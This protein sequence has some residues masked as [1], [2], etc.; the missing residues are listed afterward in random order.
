MVSE[1]QPN[2]KSVPLP[3]ELPEPTWLGG[4]TFLQKVALGTATLLTSAAL[5]SYSWS[6]HTQTQ[7]NKEYQK[8]QLL[9]R[10]ERNLSAAIETLENDLVQNLPRY[11]PGLVRESRDHSWYITVPPSAIP[12]VPPVSAVRSTP[13]LNLP[14]MQPVRGY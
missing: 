13:A 8:L 1:A 4:L 14:P 6:V 2:R 5:L 3:R 9:K 10:Q 7:W 11:V 12:T